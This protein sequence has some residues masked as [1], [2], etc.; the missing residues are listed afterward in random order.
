M[1]QIKHYKFTILVALVIVVLS[2]IPINEQTPLSDVPFI[3]KWTH[4]VMYAGMSFAMW[5]DWRGYNRHLT[6]LR[7]GLMWLLPTLMGGLLEL[8]Q[9]YLTTCRSGEW[10]DLAADAVG[11][12]VATVGCIIISTLWQKRISTRR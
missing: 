6:A 7:Y 8:V 2:V 5:L 4:C 10:L 12:A 1:E 11:A 9:A 3:D